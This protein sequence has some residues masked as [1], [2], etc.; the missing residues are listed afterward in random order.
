M[1]Q[2]F[3]KLNGLLINFQFRL[4]T[5]TADREDSR[6]RIV[7]YTTHDAILVMFRCFRISPYSE[8]LLCDCIQTSNMMINT[9]FGLAWL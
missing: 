7:L 2:D 8:L 6:F 3:V 4:Y 9:H 1:E 5:I